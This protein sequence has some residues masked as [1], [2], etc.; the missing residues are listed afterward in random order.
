MCNVGVQQF[1]GVII[2][3]P[4][5]SEPWDTAAWRYIR[6]KASGEKQP[7]SGREQKEMLLKKTA[8]LSRLMDSV[9]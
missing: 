6:S 1:L 3:I 8:A 5:V 2:K 9:Q 4:Q 7:Y